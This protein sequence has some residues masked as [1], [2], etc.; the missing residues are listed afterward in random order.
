MPILFP[1]NAGVIFDMD[2]LMLDTERIACLAW[3]EATRRAGYDMPDTIFAA[4]IGRTKH[5]SVVLLQT[6]YG[7]EFNF[8]KIYAECGAIYNEHIAQHGLPL[9]P[10]VH[11][12]LGELY[13]QKIPLGVATST[14]NPHA[15]ERLE[16]TGLLG[17]F[18]VLVTGDQ[19]THGKPAPDIYLEAARRLGI[20]P[21][22]R[23]IMVP[24]LL[25]ATPEIA[26]LTALVAASLHV[27]RTYLAE[28]R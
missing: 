15:R 23:V 25:E 28:A 22:L 2:G 6:T 1:P 7:P 20:D 21:G 16:Q 18:S 27:A 14:R 17:Y 13:A 4:M 3:K 5:D 8:E 12:L 19:I 11:E 9:K 10:G 24:D 26:A